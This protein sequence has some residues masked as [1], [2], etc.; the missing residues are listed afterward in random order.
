MARNSFSVEEELLCEIKEIA[1]TSKEEESTEV[2]EEAEPKRRVSIRVEE[3]KGNKLDIP[4]NTLSESSSSE[5]LMGK[6]YI[7]TT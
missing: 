3:P 4:P 1:V 5:T 6:K 2:E 7:Y